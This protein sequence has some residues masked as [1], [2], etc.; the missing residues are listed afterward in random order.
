MH[1]EETEAI[2]LST[3]SATGAVVEHVEL[4]ES[5]IHEIH[6]IKIASEDSPP[7]L[8]VSFS[9]SDSTGKDSSCYYWQS[10]HRQPVDM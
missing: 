5:E 10:G 9:S 4:I 7:D 8:Q 2:I 6:E 1:E 3:D